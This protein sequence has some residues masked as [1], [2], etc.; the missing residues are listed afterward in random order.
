[1][2]IKSFAL[3]TPILTLAA[4]ASAQSFA[5][6]RVG[7]VS[8]EVPANWSVVNENA[9]GAMLNPGFAPTDTLDALV[10]V[11]HG[12]LDPEDQSSPLEAVVRERL[13]D[14]AAELRDQA[15]VADFRNARPRT[16]PTASGD[17]VVIETKG[18]ANDAHDVRVWLGVVRDGAAYA[19]VLGVLTT[20]R[21]AEF[22]PPLARLHQTMSFAAAGSQAGSQVL[23]LAGTEFG[24][25]SIGSGGNSLTTVYTFAAGGSVS[26]RTMFS[27]EFGGSDSTVSG[28][29]TV[30][31]DS[32]TMTFGDGTTVATLIRGDGE[33]SGLRVGANLYSKT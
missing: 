21:A 29:W 17:G 13:P 31:G 24:R 16:V 30:E 25:S 11:M 1:M 14:L 22:L 33:V 28:T 15:I 3:F 27:S 10:V 7:D 12:E 4:A 23:S 19:V 32:V 26:R 6:L 9:D 5:H 20:G 18:R 8:F 2:K